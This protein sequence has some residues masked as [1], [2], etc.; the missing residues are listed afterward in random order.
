MIVNKIL[1]DLAE[2]T[3]A[4][5]FILYKDINSSDLDIYIVCKTG[6]P[7]F[8]SYL[9]DG[10]WIE[11]FIDDESTVDRKIE[12]SDEIAINFLRTFE[13]YSGDINKMEFYRMRAIEKAE[14]FSI[15]QDRRLLIQYRIHTLYTKLVGDKESDRL[16][17]CAMV[18]P[19][20]QLILI[21]NCIIPE[22][23]KE[24][25]NQIRKI[26]NNPLKE[27]F[28]LLMEDMISNEGLEELV[29]YSLDGYK[30]F[31]ISY[32]DTHNLTF[33]V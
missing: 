8:T 30:P 32:N 17:K 20:A 33:I 3:N 11:V 27:L 13:F 21:N 26:S 28:F 6:T 14:C 2:K 18:Y 15:S 4:V 24:W 16:I 29:K 7:S 5:S 31:S 23:P 9:V 25:V 10:R 1:H 12:N 22:S 19:L